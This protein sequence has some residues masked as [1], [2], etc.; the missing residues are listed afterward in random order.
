M[1]PSHGE[2]KGK[3]IHTA[4]VPS[5]RIIS[6][7][8]KY[9]AIQNNKFYATI[10]EWCRRFRWWRLL[11]LPWVYCHLHNVEDVWCL[12]RECFLYA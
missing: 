9:L 12:D 4:C 2:Y 11:F 7:M 6:G 10:I 1:S 5:V 8:K 3:A